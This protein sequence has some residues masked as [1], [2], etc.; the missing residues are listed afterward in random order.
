MGDKTGI[1]WTD[2]T[3]NP[4]TGCD[5]VSPGCDHCYAETFAER[6]RG[7]E[8]HYFANGFDVQ[9]RPDKLAL[10]LRWTKPRKVFVN[11]MSDL[12]HDKV[13]DDYIANVFAV[14]A[15]ATLHTF[16]VL[17]KRHGR[18]RSL[19]SSD[20]FRRRMY[21]YLVSIDYAWIRDNPLSWPLPNVWLGVSA[22]DQKRADL[23]IP[24]L[25][26]TPATVRF[27]SAEPLLGPINL[28][29]D[30]IEA[31]SPFWGSQLDWVIVGGESGPGARPMHPD[32]A[33][34][35]RDQCVAAGVPFLFKQWGE[36]R[37][38]IPG[39]DTWDKVESI[40]LRPDVPMEPGVDIGPWA[41]MRRVGK[42]RAGRDLDGRTWDQYPEVVR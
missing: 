37:I 9:L 41:Y 24:A 40:P 22:E 12:F 23:R 11:S 35:L 36:H 31:G 5:K 15:R 16:Q 30:P 25:L 1:E 3:W 4:I 7:T 39:Q 34:S 6:W 2:A 20:L 8:G 26:D 21:D 10:P 38:A 32:W 27:V 42:R 33:R 13:P 18:M 28:H 17:T 29:T 19:L 14:M